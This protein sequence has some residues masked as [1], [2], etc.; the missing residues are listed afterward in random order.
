MSD[1]NRTPGTGGDDE[2]AD[3]DE[4]RQARALAEALEGQDEPSRPRDEALGTAALVAGTRAPVLTETAKARLGDEL[5]GAVRRRTPMRWPLAAAAAVLVAASST[6]VA[7]GYRSVAR[8]RAEERDRTHE[9]AEALVAALLD[10]RGP[11]DRADAI[12]REAEGAP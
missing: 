12:A 10:G 11:A 3:L 2:P 9:A 4:A 6:L 7:V 8:A 5:F 1:E